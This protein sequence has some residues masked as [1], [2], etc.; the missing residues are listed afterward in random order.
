MFKNAG[1]EKDVVLALHVQFSHQTIPEDVCDLLTMVILRTS[2][3][4]S[5]ES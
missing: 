5:I 2:V 3:T 1:L 4:A